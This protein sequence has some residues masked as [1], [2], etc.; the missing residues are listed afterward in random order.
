MEAVLAFAG[1]HPFFVQIACYHLFARK[2]VEGELDAANYVAWQDDAY[3]DSQFHFQGAW[4]RLNTSEQQA[5]K[6][7]ATGAT[8]QIQS[9]LARELAGTG[10]SCCN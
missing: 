5:L 6:Q 2:E 9:N 1:T 8:A 7:L 3:Q 10:V 4:Q